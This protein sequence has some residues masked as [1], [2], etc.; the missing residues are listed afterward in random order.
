MSAASDDPLTG[1]GMCQAFWGMLGD[2]ER[3]AVLKVAGTVTYDADK[4]IIKE[5]EPPGIALVIRSGWVKIAG[6]ATSGRRTALALRT[7]GDLVGESASADHPRIATV[8]AL[9]EVKALII[10][11]HDFLELLHS[12]PMV[13]RALQRTHSERQSESD[14]KCMNFATA[15]SSQRLA[16]LFLDLAD[17]VGGADDGRH[18]LVL[19]I[20]ISQADISQLICTSISTVERTLGNWRGRGIIE[21][22][23]RGCELLDLPALRRI[24]GSGH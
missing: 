17:R 20:P 7:A 4:Q 9:G 11:A 8:Y 18:K 12:Y 6:G 24:A 19:D 10:T 21:T 15:S 23:Y 16:Q 3:H 22:R 1:T 13:E 5:G 2:R 14:R